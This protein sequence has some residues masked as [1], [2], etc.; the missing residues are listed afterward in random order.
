[1]R[2]LALSIPLHLIY[3]AATFFMEAI[4]KPGISTAVMWGAN[5]V[6][7]TLNLLWVPEHGA[8]GSAWAT[9][10][11]RV[12]LS[13]VLLLCVLFMRDGA[14]FGVRVRGVTG[15][16]Y[17]ALLAVGVAAAVSQAV[18]AGAGRS[19]SGHATPSWLRPRRRGSG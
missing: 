15:P 16:S 17:G 14:K 5:V 10:C 9:V 18:E 4:K 7:L 11:A 13:V 12:F 3:V 2:V 1:M 6:N 19:R 8:I